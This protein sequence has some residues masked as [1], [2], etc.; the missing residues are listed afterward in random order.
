VVTCLLQVFFTCRMQHHDMWESSSRQHCNLS[1]YMISS[2]HGHLHNT[3]CMLYNSHLSM[4]ACVAVYFLMHAG[5]TGSGAAL[6]WQRMQQDAAAGCAARVIDSWQ[7]QLQHMRKTAPGPYSLCSWRCAPSLSSMQLHLVFNVLQQTRTVLFGSAC[8]TQA[9][10]GNGSSRRIG[11][12]AYCSR[13]QMRVLR[14]FCLLSW[15]AALLVYAFAFWRQGSTKD[16]PCLAERFAAIVLF[17]VPMHACILQDGACPPRL[18]LPVGQA[19]RNTCH[20][21]LPSY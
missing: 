6:Q 18:P 11:G 8:S 16:G 17:F 9:L 1:C 7:E 19:C 3:R 4:S 5:A 14:E 20:A 12:T 10:W 21:V 13:Q 2:M 15:H